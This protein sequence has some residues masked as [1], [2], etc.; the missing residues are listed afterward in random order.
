VCTDRPR[1]LLFAAAAWAA[2]APS[3][4]ADD[5]GSGRMRREL[6]LDRLEHLTS[7]DGLAHNWILELYQ[8]RRGFLWIGTS[9]GLHRY[10]GYDLKVY[11]G[12]PDDPATLADNQVRALLEDGHGDLWVGT[13]GGLHR[14]NRSTGAF[15]RFR[16]DP[17][18]PACLSDDFVLDLLEESSG[19]QSSG[20]IW[21]AT[22]DGLNRFDPSSASFERFYHDAGDPGS[23]SDSFV[24]ALFESRS[25]ELWVGSRAATLNLL[26]RS[27]GAFRRYP[28]AEGETA[29]R[30]GLVRAVAEDADGR[31]WVA[32]G[33]ALVRFDPRTGERRRYLEDVLHGGACLAVEVMPDGT[34]WVG[35]ESSGLAV[36][37][38]GRSRSSATTR[39]T[40]ARSPPAGS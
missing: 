10:D 39:T 20:G 18:D 21:A 36:L 12:D 7:K 38:P 1:N 15:T 19:G 24:A 2:L 31:L 9:D 26:D 30:A 16:H 25:G 14:L 11:R 23:L 35:T 17:A 6:R 37:D 3:L 32:T 27:S 29:D 34:L 13:R 40:P 33:G 28:L 22:R 4:A 8:D 5:H